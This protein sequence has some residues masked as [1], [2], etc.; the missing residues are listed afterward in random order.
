MSKKDYD[1]I[2]LFKTDLY[3]KQ[4]D[5]DN[6]KILKYISKIDK[7]SVI[8]KASNFGGWHSHFYFDPF[9]SCLEPL[10]EQINKFVKETIHKDFQVRGDLVIHNGW[11]I[12]NKKGDFNKPHKHPPY[13]FSG[14]YYLKCDDDSGELIFNNQAEMN[15]Y[16]VDYTDFNSSNSKEF[17]IKPQEG[18]LYIWPAWIEHYVTPNKSDS[19]RIVYSFN[20]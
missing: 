19:E 13:T 2:T 18:Q 1:Q 11:F 16:A 15:N 4:L 10:N 17:Y 9:P 7:D 8:V 6:T 20:I 12:V 5:F 3:A 14:V